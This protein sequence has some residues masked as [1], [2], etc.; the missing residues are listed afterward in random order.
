MGLR[1]HRYRPPTT[2]F[3]VGA[4]GEGVPAPSAT[5][6]ANARSRTASPAASSSPPATRTGG[7]QGAARQ[8]VIQYGSTPTTSPGATSRNSR[9]PAT[10][11]GLRTAF[12]LGEDRVGGV[13]GAV[14]RVVPALDLPR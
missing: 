11:A 10:A 7:H 5:N 6:R 9:L 12:S 13:A 8:P 14:D 2:S 1:T 3:S 4:A